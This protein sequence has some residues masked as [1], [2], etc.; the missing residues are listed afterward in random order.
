MHQIYKITNCIPAV[1]DHF[2]PEQRITKTSEAA[3]VIDSQFRQY[4]PDSSTTTPDLLNQQGFILTKK[5]H[6]VT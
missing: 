2:L 3:I 4:E 6:S 5:S 1:Q